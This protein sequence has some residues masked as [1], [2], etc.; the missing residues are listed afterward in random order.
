M[1]GVDHAPAIP[2]RRRRAGFV[3]EAHVEG[4]G[5]GAGAGDAPELYCL[6]ALGPGSG[7]ALG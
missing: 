5:L 1:A 2:K 4:Y 3:V 7:E 6:P